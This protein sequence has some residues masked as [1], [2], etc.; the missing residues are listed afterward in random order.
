MRMKVVNNKTDKKI[1]Q[2][3]AR[4]HPRNVNISNTRG[5]IRM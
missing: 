3:A 2:T 1:F 5:G 4:R